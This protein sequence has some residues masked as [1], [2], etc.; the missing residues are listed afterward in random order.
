LLC[1][2]RP[3]SIVAPEVA[4]IF[5]GTV[6]SAGGWVRVGDHLLQDR[7][8]PEE[9]GRCAVEVLQRHDIP[10][11]LE[12]SEALLCTPR[13][14]QEIRARVRPPLPAEGLGNGLQ[15]LIDAITLPEDL[16]SSS[17]AKISVWGSPIRVEQLAAEIGDGVGALPNSLTGDVSSGELH[18]ASVD[19]A[20]GMLLAAE[21][22]GFGQPATVGI[23]DGLN[24]LGMLR[25]AGTAIGVDGPPA[26]VLERAGG[27]RRG[28]RA[29]PSGA[30]PGHRLRPARADRGAP[31][32]PG[33]RGQ[34]RRCSPTRTR[35]TDITSAPAP[36][37]ITPWGVIAA[38]KRPSRTW[39]MGPR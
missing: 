27:A 9:L 16:A 30:R 22:L 11:A 12:T 14:A 32:G 21:H 35:P 5:D 29:G 37:R 26:A 38:S 3:A 10:F 39:T 31:A 23:G 1:T 17:F 18:L 8:F 28:E 34:L 4:E 24:D 19:K 13:S 2:G 20:D 7:R 36:S 15:D 33:R 25:A 6:A